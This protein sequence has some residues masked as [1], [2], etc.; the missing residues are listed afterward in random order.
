MECYCIHCPVLSCPLLPF[1]CCTEFPH[2]AVAAAVWQHRRLTYHDAVRWY[3]DDTV[4]AQLEG[5]E[6]H[7]EL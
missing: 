4:K 2:D 5:Q 6:Y 7:D 3:N 1:V